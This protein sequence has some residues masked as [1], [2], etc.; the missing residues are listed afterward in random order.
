MGF[1]VWGLGFG[2]WGGMLEND[3]A[4]VIGIPTDFYTKLLSLE[5]TDRP[6]LIVATGGQA[7]TMATASS[8]PKFMQLI[9]VNWLH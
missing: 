8:K 7:V 1:G 6:A 4:H 3:L 2:V 5:S 9:L